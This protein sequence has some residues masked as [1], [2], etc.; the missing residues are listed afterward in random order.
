MNQLTSAILKHFPDWNKRVHTERDAEEFCEKRGVI[1]IETD[2]IDDLGEYLVRREKPVILLHKFI[3]REYRTWVF[4]HECGHEMFHSPLNC[5]F[6]T[7]T[8]RK[9]ELQANLVAAVAL[10]P[11]ELLR[12][13]TLWE[14]KEEYD[15]PQK[16]VLLREYIWN[17][18]RV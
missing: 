15:Y 8:R 18:F 7:I 17:T 3:A 9:V 4:L 14:I 10:I 6:S 16:L 2:L 5:R 1:V 13:K 12:T 11:V